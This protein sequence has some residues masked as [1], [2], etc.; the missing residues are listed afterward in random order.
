MTAIHNGLIARIKPGDRILY[1]G[2]Y[3][4]FGQHAVECVDEILAFRRLILCIPGMMPTDFIYLRGQQ[5]QMWQKLL[6]LPFAPDPMNVLLW[7]LGNGL[8]TTLYSYGLCP[9]DAIEACRAGTL[10]L[11]KWIAKVREAVRKHP[12]HE[13]FANHQTRAAFTDEEQSYPM[14]FIHAGLNSAYNLQDQ[15]DNLWWGGEDFDHVAQAY[16]PFEKVIRGYDPAHRGLYLNC[17]TATTDNACGFGGN[18]IS[19]GFETDG[20]VHEIL[21]S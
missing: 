13:T 11:T 9:H 15:G 5:E 3:T 4:G 1:H 12:G 16:K 2:N 14:L 7:M 20:S 18:L 6:Q 19:V 17:I 10:P 8:S 21:E